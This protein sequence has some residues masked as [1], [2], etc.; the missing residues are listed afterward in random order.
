MPNLRD[1]VLTAFGAI[2]GIPNLCSRQSRLTVNSSL[3]I[4]RRSSIL[5]EL[6]G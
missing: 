1:L 4:S 3:Q 2:T 5:L 6:R